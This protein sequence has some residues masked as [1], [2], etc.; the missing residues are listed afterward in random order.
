MRVTSERVDTAV[1]AS[2][3]A[4][5][6][7]TFGNRLVNLVQT[8][9]SPACQFCHVRI[10]GSHPPRAFQVFQR[11]FVLAAPK[12]GIGYVHQ[13]YRLVWIVNQRGSFIGKSMFH[14]A[15]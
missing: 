7:A 14:I 2:A 15:V 13:Q 3:V 4:E 8:V 11:L 5:L 9:V 6:A 10:I 12:M 1:I